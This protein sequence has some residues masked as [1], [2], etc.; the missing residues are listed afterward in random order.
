M[1]S[2]FPCVTINDLAEMSF[3]GGTNQILE[4]DIYNSSGSPI[5][6]SSS[7]VSWAMSPYGNPSYVV[8]S[9]TGILAVSPL[10]RFSVEI[11]NADTASLYGKFTH[12]PIII[13]YLGNEFRP[14]QGII[15]IIPA[16]R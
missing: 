16:N 6:L 12:Q 2:Q 7:T 14:S 11:L 3:I 10:N 8:L 4:F 5:D 1:T 15:T 13:D 9:K